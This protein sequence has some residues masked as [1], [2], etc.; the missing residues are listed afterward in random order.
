MLL[1]PLPVEHS[2]MDELYRSWEP[3][4]EALGKELTALRLEFPFLR[5]S[6]PPTDLCGWAVAGCS[7]TNLD[8]EVIVYDNALSASALEARHYP[9]VNAFFR[10]PLN[11]HHSP[12]I[13]WALRV[14]GTHV[15][16][17]TCDGVSSV[18]I[19]KALHA[20]LRT[21]SVKPVIGGGDNDDPVEDT[22]NAM[23]VDHE[24]G[25]EE[26]ED[27]NV[28]GGEEEGEDLMEM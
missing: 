6:P 7:E 21:L 26:E 24:D 20:R 9:S 15:T 25:E 3:P 1:I 16:L 11:V 13:M 22:P 17:A 27:D 23:L 19:A 28:E 4:L 2:R 14:F 8:V 10:D 5:P 12:A 18:S